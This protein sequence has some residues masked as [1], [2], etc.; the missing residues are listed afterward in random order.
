MGTI[1]AQALAARR[2]MLLT[3]MTPE[4]IA[5]N[6]LTDIFESKIVPM[7]DTQ[8][9]LGPR[10][11]DIDLDWSYKERL[12]EL[13]DRLQNDFKFRMLFVPGYVRE[14]WLK[15][16]EAI[17]AGSLEVRAVTLQRRRRAAAHEEGASTALNSPGGE[18]P[19]PGM[20][21]DRDDDVAAEVAAERASR[22][23]SAWEKLKAQARLQRPGS[24]TLTRQAPSGA[25]VR[26][27]SLFSDIGSGSAS[28]SS[29]PFSERFSPDEFDSFENIEGLAAPTKDSTAGA[30]G[31]GGGRGDGGRGA[32]GRELPISEAMSLA[33]IREF[34]RR[35]SLD[36]E[37]KTSGAGRT[38]QAILKDIAAVWLRRQASAGRGGVVDEG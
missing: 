26:A 4:A 36:R 34:V 20:V 21:E 9:R 23:S 10:L 18:A 30:G 19:G 28:E 27:E 1:D 33:E 22:A 25:S 32:G 31:A 5:L 6:C 2:D 29:E 14:S 12:W 35:E 3:Q 7:Q 37:V 11:R 38:K 15:K 13:H 17:R 8:T 16:K 24:R